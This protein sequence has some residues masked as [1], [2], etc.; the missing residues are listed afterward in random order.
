MPFAK[1]PAAKKVAAKPV[2]KK[3]AAK[4]LAKAPAKKTAAV[5]KAPAKAPVRKGAA[6]SG[7]VPLKETLNKSQLIQHLADATELDRKDVAKVYAALENAMAGAACKKGAGVFMLPG[8]LKVT[9]LDV[10]AKP[11][12]K[13]INPFTGEEQVFAAK[14]ATVKVKIRPLKKLKDAALS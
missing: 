11:K 1:K 12:R 2:A 4:P 9:V 3:P 6:A 14:P 5:K 13:G 10:P 7:I 8:F